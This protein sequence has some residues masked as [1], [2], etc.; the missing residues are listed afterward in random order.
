[1][2]FFLWLHK[3][4]LLYQYDHLYAFSAQANFNGL[5]VPACLENSYLPIYF[6][7]AAD[8]YQ[9]TEGLPYKQHYF[10]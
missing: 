9:L 5:P 3:L 1:M 7:L 8:Q 4:I 10:F 6:L 2:L